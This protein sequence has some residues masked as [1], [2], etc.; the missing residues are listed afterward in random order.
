MSRVI[1]L[2]LFLLFVVPA[3]GQHRG[4]FG[5]GLGRGRAGAGFGRGGFITGGLARGRSQVV[6]L[7]GGFGFPSQGFTNLGIPPVGPIPPLGLNSSFFGFDRRFGFRHHFF[8]SSGFFPYALPLFTGGY[9]YG[10][11]FSLTHTYRM[12]WLP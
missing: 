9:D 6:V 2:C 7:V 8:P 3:S 10:F 4:G 1:W 5:A 12:P 11:T